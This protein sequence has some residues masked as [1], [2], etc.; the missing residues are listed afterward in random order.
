MPD[1]EQDPKP[2]E[3]AIQAPPLTGRPST[4][5]KAKARE[6]CELLSEGVPLREICRKDGMP[7][8]RTVYDWMAKD[9]ELSTSIAHARDLGWDAIW[10]DCLRIADT[11]CIGEVTID[12]G[13][14]LVVR[15]EDMLG[16]RKLQIETRMK[17]L[18]K[19]NPK[20]YGDVLRHAGDVENPLVVDVMAKE[21]VT[22]LVKNIEMKRQLQNAG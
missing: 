4:Y 22:S 1:T 6:I 9:E 17:M 10:E 16:H 18:A 2:Q 5:T 11:P 19:F 12:D 7:A 13:E 20:K 21:V 15:R 3:A 14:K 8:W